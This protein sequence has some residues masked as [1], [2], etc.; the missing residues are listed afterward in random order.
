[1]TS[2]LELTEF[3]PFGAEVH[4]DLSEPLS[5]ATKAELAAALARHHL[6]RFR[7]QTFS[8]EQQIDVMSSF[9]PVNRDEGDI[10][11]RDYITKDENLGENLGSK[12]LAYH[13]DLAHSPVPMIAIS[14][15]ALDVE[16]GTTSTRYI[17]SASVFRNLPADLRRRIIGLDALHVWP[18]RDGSHGEHIRSTSPGGVAVDLRLPYAVHPLVMLHPVTGESILYMNEMMTDRIEGLSDDESEALIAELDSYLYRPENVYEHW[19]AIGD[20]IIWDNLAVQHGRPDQGAVSRRTLR[21]VLCA[22]KSIYEQ[23]PQMKWSGGSAVY[24]DEYA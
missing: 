13:S 19:W 9:G 14:L 17:D 15:Y 11:P 16:D 5:D 22:E 1:V 3:E 4:I 23:H 24:N 6:L 7:D 18:T 20:Y 21:R 2:T 8:F 12:P 10:K